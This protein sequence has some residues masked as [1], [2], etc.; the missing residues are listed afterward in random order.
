VAPQAPAPPASPFFQVPNCLVLFT[1]LAFGQAE[2]QPWN[3]DWNPRRGSSGRP[4][5]GR[6]RVGKSPR[7][8]GNS[9]SKY[10][11][12]GYYGSRPYN[13]YKVN[14]NGGLGPHSGYVRAQ[15]PQQTVY[16][17]RIP[18]H[19][20]T[21][22][23]ALWQTFARFGEIER[24]WCSGGRGNTGYGFVRFR[25]PSSASQA[26]KVSQQQG[27]IRLL[28][29]GPRPND[30]QDGGDGAPLVVKWAK[31][32]TTPPR[33]YCDLDGVLCDFIKKATEILGESPNDIRN[34]RIPSELSSMWEK[35]KGFESGF[36]S[37]LPWM[38]GGQIL[39][40]AISGL[41]P[42][43]ITG[44]PRGEWAQPQKRKWVAK[45]L[46]EKVNVHT[47][48]AP[49]KPNHCR[50]GDVLIDD[51]AT[52][53][54][55]WEA[56]R[57]FY[58]HHTDVES[59]LERLRDLGVLP[60]LGLPA[61]LFLGKSAASDQKAI[62]AKGTEIICV[63]KASRVETSEC[64]STQISQVNVSGAAVVHFEASG[65]DQA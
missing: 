60:P 40:K 53:G 18:R 7:G 42:A 17:G 15:G 57:G 36:Y 35:L 37:S 34:R 12:G 41:S 28:E 3:S 16:V 50:D 11:R 4:W 10:A 33:V 38:E 45:H 54:P 64:G 8:R 22:A 26:L 20:R 44:C 5:G 47:C 30:R 46:G 19:I 2:M 32:R 6:R 14:R 23:R 58:V 48:F 31:G 13:D 9:Y 49:K 55:S 29:S 52:L 62:D 63:E 56:R 43:I 59:T 61:K 39:W 25:E 51:S 24:T 27:G 21:P 1:C 65:E